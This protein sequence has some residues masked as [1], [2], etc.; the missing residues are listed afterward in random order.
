MECPVEGCT[1]HMA[2][3]MAPDV[4]DEIKATF[5]PLL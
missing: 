3:S 4:S 2:W 5:K 1:C